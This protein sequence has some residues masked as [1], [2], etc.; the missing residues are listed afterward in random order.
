[1]THPTWCHNPST[2]HSPKIEIS[3]GRA[4]R[5]EYNFLVS[6]CAGKKFAVKGLAADPSWDAGAATTVS[7]GK[8]PFDTGNRFGCWLQWNPQRGY[9]MRQQGAEKDLSSKPEKHLKEMTDRA[10]W[11]S[12]LSSSQV[13]PL[14]LEATSMSYSLAH[15][16]HSTACDMQ[17]TGMQ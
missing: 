11:G 10:S 5:E 8:K 4:T 9:S 2:P 16:M 6:P 17:L 12:S 7:F 3:R 13:E 14:K 1:M 15:V